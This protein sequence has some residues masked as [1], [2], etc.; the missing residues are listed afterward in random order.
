MGGDCPPHALFPA[1]SKAAA[2]I[3]AAH[4]LLVIAT[5]PVCDELISFLSQRSDHHSAHGASVL[6]QVVSESIN[7][8]EDPLHAVR[9]K[10]NSSLVVGVDMIREGQIDAFVSCGSTGALIAA[11][12][13]K[14][15]PMPGIV[16]PALLVPLPTRKGPVAVLDV[17]GNVACKAENLIHFALLG[18]AYQKAVLGIDVPKM[19][20]LNI[21]VESKK[22]TV[23]VRRAYEY[24]NDYRSRMTE[25][26]RAP[27]FEFVGNIEG[28]DIFS[29]CVDVLVTDGFSGNIM[30]KTTEGAAAFIFE[31]LEEAI[32]DTSS[33]EFIR[34]F[35]TLKKQ[36]NY[37]EYPGAIVCGV[38]GV[39]MKVHGNATE[40]TLFVTIMAAMDCV[41]RGVIKDIKELL[42]TSSTYV[43]KKS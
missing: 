17:G 6:F 19:G 13:L 35:L 26:G 1:V 23:E 32:A 38:E 41:N 2:S 22:G 40:D 14:L 11:S 21:G 39:L 3:S 28:R 33:D 42:S 34:K 43:L 20:L 9:N 15:T 27:L 5:Q 24:L 8:S 30:L 25:H 18:A 29:G 31:T 10:Q 37:A 36:F 16:R 7:M 12:V 4:S